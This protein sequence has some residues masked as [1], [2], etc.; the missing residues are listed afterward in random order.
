MHFST[1]DGDFK[2]ISSVWRNIFE[3]ERLYQKYQDDTTEGVLYKMLLHSL[4]VADIP[5]EL[6]AFSSTLPSQGNQQREDKKQ[7]DISERM[8]QIEDHAYKYT[9]NRTVDEVIERLRDGILQ[10]EASLRDAFLACSKQ[11]SGK[12]SR[13][14]FHKLL[15]DI[16]MPM[17]DDQF[18][19]LIEKIGFPVGGL[20]YLDFVAIFEDSRLS[21]RSPNHP[22]NAIKCHFLSAEECLSQYSDKLAEEYGDPYIAFRKIDQNNDGIITMLDFRRLLDSFMISMADEEYI[23]LLG[24]LGMSETSTLNYLEFLQLFQAH[25]T[26]EMRPWLTP[27]Y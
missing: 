8:K 4:G 1:Y 25:A 19:L 3:R 17:N 7:I 22:A 26:K 6:T 27:S 5:K 15:D 23:R 13:S 18:N 2:V 21:G 16:G 9:K 20:S 11:A 12:L 24:I 14:D 10:Q